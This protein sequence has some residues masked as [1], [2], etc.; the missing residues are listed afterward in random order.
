[1]GWGQALP[2]GGHATSA[3]FSLAVLWGCDPII[4]VAQDLAYTGGRI[5]ASGR[6]GGEDEKR[7]EM[8]KV[9]AIG[10]GSVATSPVMRSYLAWYQEAAAH[11]SALG[12][13]P[14]LINAT[15]A[16]ARIPGFIHLDLAEALAGLPEVTVDFTPVLT[17]LP[18]LPRP[19]AAYLA[20]RL[21]R[22]KSEIKTALAELPEKG[23]EAVL[24]GAEGSPAAAA[25]LADLPFSAGAD[26]AM[27]ALNQM[28]GTLTAMGEGLY[29]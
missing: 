8:V 19:Q 5:H 6:P 18:R 15:A 29:A 13:G 2:T 1:V 23:L 9:P 7:P 28:L 17:A 11:L 3:A 10:G 27:E 14:R 22:A 20:Q 26:Q 4:L 16:G 12:R 21:A 24:A 25:A